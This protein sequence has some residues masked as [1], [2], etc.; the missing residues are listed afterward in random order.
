MAELFAGRYEPLDVIGK[1][2]TGSVWR[3]YDHRE[4]RLIAAKL[5]RQSDKTSLLRFVMEQAIRI[6]H[7]HVLSPLGWAAEDDRVILTMPLADGG[8]IGTLMADVR[9]L[10]PR[11]VAEVLRQL[12]CALEAVHEARVVHRDVTPAN[13]LLRA[14]GTDRPHVFLSDFGIAA[15]EDGPYLLRTES[16]SGTPGFAAPEQ[17]GGA[18]PQPSAD[19]YSVGQVARQMLTGWPPT[20]ERSM[21]RPADTPGVLWDLIEELTSQDPA[22]RPTSEEARRRLGTSELAWN[23]EAIGAV[24]VRKR[25][26]DMVLPPQQDERV[27]L[28][29]VFPQQGGAMAAG[30]NRWMWA[31][32]ALI[33]A[34]VA[35]ALVVGMVELWQGMS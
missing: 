6:H 15:N 7:P 8:S 31:L 35:V 12:L 28:E 19:L 32:I 13:L 21:T 20:S 4:R 10:P 11:F 9:R 24:D 25:V 14:T 23:P 5:L 26:D 16:M 2:A 18:D 34:I 17:M 22:N 1:G 30:S 27:P 33:A 3:V 29:E